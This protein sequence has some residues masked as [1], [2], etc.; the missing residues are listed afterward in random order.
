MPPGKKIR[1]TPA[2]YRTRPLSEV[3]WLAFK[4]LPDEEKNAFLRLLLSGPG[5]Y[6]EIADAVEMIEAGNEPTRPLEEFE[7]D[8]RR[9]GRLTAASRSAAYR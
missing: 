4:S 5:T 3:F 6:D 9:E 1:E 2:P 8:L 7:E